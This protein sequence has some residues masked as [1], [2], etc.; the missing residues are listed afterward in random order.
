VPLPLPSDGLQAVN[1]YVIETERG[2]VCIDGG[3]AIEESRLQLVASLATIGYHP[4]DISDFLVTHVHRD[5]YTQ[6]V[7]L[8]SE[9]GATV[10]LGSGERFALTNLRTNSNRD[11]FARR[12]QRAGAQAEAKGWIEIVLGTSHDPSLWQEPD[13]WIEGGSDI[14]TGD[15]VLRAVATPGHTSGHLVFADLDAGLLF[16]GDHVLPTITPSIGFEG[17]PT[18]ASPLDDYLTSL[19]RVRALPDLALLPAHGDTEMRSHARIDQLLAHHEERL[20]LSLAA[21]ASGMTTA[22]E[23][24]AALPWTRH[25]RALVDLDPFNL[26]IAVSE[27]LAHLDVLVSR[28]QATREVVD[29]IARYVAL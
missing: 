18:T 2:L 8:R 26:A 7:A 21:V 14:P 25:Q 27:T 23:V 13:H 19:A 5:H 6:A 4:R 28:G 29:M 24:A 22:R 15:R 12:L 17:A 16:A 20:A 1:V 11:L 3:W 10:S 9:F